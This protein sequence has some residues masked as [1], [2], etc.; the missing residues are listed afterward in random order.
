MSSRP[1]SRQ[2]PASLRRDSFS[3]ERDPAQEWVKALLSLDPKVAKA[4]RKASLAE[5]EKA[6]TSLGGFPA[7]TS[8]QEAVVLLHCQSR[9]NPALCQL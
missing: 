4:Q 9:I 6:Q 8:A 1:F 7:S 5:L 3:A 2:W